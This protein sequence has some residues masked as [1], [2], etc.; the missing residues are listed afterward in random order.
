MEHPTHGAQRLTDELSGR[1][2]K[3]N[4]GGVQGVWSRH[5]LKT[6]HERLLR[7]EETAK[8]AKLKHTDE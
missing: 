3:V 2:V 7:L 6:K 1:E 4:S 5:A 8:R